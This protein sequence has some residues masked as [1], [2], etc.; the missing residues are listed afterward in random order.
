MKKLCLSFLWLFLFYSTA[1]SQSNCSSTQLL[2]IGNTCNFTTVQKTGNETEK[3]F[4][5]YP[6]K[7]Q[8]KLF[9]IDPGDVIAK[10]QIYGINDSIYPYTNC[11]ASGLYYS[12]SSIQ[13]NADS[14]EFY[15]PQTGIPYMIKLSTTLT[16]TT[17]TFSVGLSEKY[18]STSWTYLFNSN[19][20]S[21]TCSGLLSNGTGYDGNLNCNTITLCV[22]EVLDLSMD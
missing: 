5:F 17:T 11:S 18:E 2:S 3:W 14:M 10:A 1:V 12:D 4:Y 9:F 16:N 20:G 15:V 7:N 8:I 6:T 22:D 13:L 19:N 21:S